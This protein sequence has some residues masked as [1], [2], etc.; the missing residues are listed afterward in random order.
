[1]SG[2]PSHDKACNL[3][4]DA[5]N[6]R[7]PAVNHMATLVE[8]SVARRVKQVEH[9]AEAKHD[10]GGKVDDHQVRNVVS[11]PEVVNHELNAVNDQ[12]VGNE[13][14]DDDEPQVNV[15]LVPRPVFNLVIRMVGGLLDVS[16]LAVASAHLHGS[17]LI[18]GRGSKNHF[19][20]DKVT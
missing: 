1:M 10:D 2:D 5:G 15:A 20:V 17:V 7:D 16:N 3:T 18:V 12:E 8:R 19:G 13:E 11:T 6:E 4:D 14:P 9:A